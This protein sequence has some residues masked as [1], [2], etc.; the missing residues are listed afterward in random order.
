MRRFF[1]NLVNKARRGG[2]KAAQRPPR[3]ASLQVEVLE[4]REVPSASAI[5][6]LRPIPAN[7]NFGPILARPHPVHAYLD[8]I[9]A[10]YLSLGGTGGFLGSPVTGE[11]ALS[12]QDGNG[13]YE[14]FQHGAIF[15]SSATGAHEIHG[16]IETEWFNIAHEQDA[17]GQNVQYILSFPTSDEMNGPWGKGRMN[18]FQGGELQ[19]GG[20]GGA[21]VVYG[22]IVGEYLHTFWERDAYGVR[23]QKILGLATSDEMDV[24]GVAGA[25]M[26]T[27]QGGTIY[28]SP[29]T[30]A[31]VVY[32]GIAAKYNSV[33]G[34][35]GYGLPVS[36]EANVPHVPGERVTYFQSP[37]FGFTPA[38]YWSAST[39]AHLVYGAVGLEYTATA[40]EYGGMVQRLLG[41]PTSDEMDVPGVAGA[42]MNTFQGGTI[43]WSPATGGHVVYGE[44]AAKYNSIGG[45]QSFLGLPTTDPTV[46][47]GGWLQYFQDGWIFWSST[48]GAVVG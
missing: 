20:G 14:L 40:S 13:L 1:G 41:A 27:F 9:Q 28:W 18:T 30:G 35:V 11:M 44:I 5:A 38:I 3:R 45:P 48:G 21:H 10:K 15:W 46:E 43:Y 7:V 4:G 22:G 32:G 34:P 36:D 2:T 37:G 12:T 16:A 31:H 23:V 6:N 33:G 42:R 26:N 47:G 17:Y 29:D 39:G 8:P 24:P 25:R 19:W